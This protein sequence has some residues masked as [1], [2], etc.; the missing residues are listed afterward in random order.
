MSETPIPAQAWKAYLALLVT[1]VIWGVSPAYIRSFS[2]AAG[3][4]DSIFIRLVAVAL[5]C[6]ALLPF[7]GWRVARQDWLRFLLASW[8]GI[9]GYFLGSIYGFAFITAG[10]GGLL[11]ATQPLMIA[12]LAALAGTDRLTAPMLLGFGLAFAGTLY[13]LSGELSLGGTNPVLGALLILACGAAFT[14]NVVLSKPLV[15]SYGPL[16]VTFVNLALAGLPALLFYRS[17]A[18]N[19]LANLDADA[20]FALFYLGPL[21]TIFASIIWNYAV[22]KLPPS[23]VG[24]S[25]YMI[26]ILSVLAGWLILGETVSAHTILAGLIILSGVAIAEYGK[27]LVARFQ[28]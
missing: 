4:H 26:P 2:L 3:P 5:L 17:E 11:M 10:P 27:V 25:L 1:V 28:M 7:S 16:R 6:A 24:G 15:Q 21:G 19:V 12:G 20:W 8:I 23:S 22:G 14:V 18:W 13:L 9:F